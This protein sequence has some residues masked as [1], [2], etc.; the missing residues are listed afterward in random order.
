MSDVIVVGGGPAGSMTALLLARAGRDVTLLEQH[1]FPRAKPCGDCIS[2]GANAI[3]ERTG[4]LGAVLA[5]D[6]AKLRGWRLEAP[7]DAAF[8][9]EFGGALTSIAME[10]YRFDAILLDAARAAGVSIRTGARVTDLIRAHDGRVVGVAARLSGEPTR[11]SA[12]LTVGAD[13]LRSRI[14][15]RLGAI[16]RRP[17]LR[18]I[19]LTVHAR[20]VPHI[21]EIGEM[22]L[23]E[24]V[25][26]GVAPVE[27][28]D[29]PV[30]NITVVMAA[31]HRAKQSATRNRPREMLRGALGRFPQRNLSNLITDDLTVLAS[32]PFDWPVHRIVHDGAVLIGDAAG[33]YD[34]FTGQGIY[35]ALA[36]AELLAAHV[37][38]DNLQTFARAQRGLLSPARRIQRGIEFVCARPLLTRTAFRA[39]A[40]APR[41]ATRLIHVTG[42][43]RPARDLIWF[44]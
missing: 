25:C 18:K 13:G 22:H 36:S 24:G 9:N 8:E 42:D 31:D 6:P 29:N 14:A 34:P 40:R 3:L 15:R 2:P 43:L 35:Q 30:C 27:S 5:G 28:G 21:R 38:A 37:V 1:A 17:R 10:R 32:G 19:S 44:S 7:P 33:Y 26:L 12:A 41:M 23:S 4:I 20:G 11:F 39:L 16:E